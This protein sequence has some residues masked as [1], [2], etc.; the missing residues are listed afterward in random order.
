M[1]GVCAGVTEALIVTPFEVKAE[2]DG[3]DRVGDEG[4]G[5]G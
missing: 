2:Q 4:C 3:E 1:A 5:S